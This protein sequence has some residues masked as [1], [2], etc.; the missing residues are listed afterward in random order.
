MEHREEPLEKHNRNKKEDK[1]EYKQEDLD[2]NKLKQKI[3]EKKVEFTFLKYSASRY[4]NS[5]ECR[6]LH[7]IVMKKET[8]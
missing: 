5:F 8:L 6:G 2:L 3:Q 4:I 1:R 7:R